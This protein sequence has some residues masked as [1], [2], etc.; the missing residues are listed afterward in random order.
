MPNT[1]I[2]TRMNYFPMIAFHIGCIIY[3]ARLP[4]PFLRV[5]KVQLKICIGIGH[6]YFDYLQGKQFSC[7][8]LIKVFRYLD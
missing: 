6:C 8:I 2:C 7:K 5:I 4:V 3:I 1:T